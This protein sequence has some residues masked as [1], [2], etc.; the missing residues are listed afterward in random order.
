MAVA[1]QGKVFVRSGGGIVKDSIPE[2]NTK[3]R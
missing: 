2:M 3:K 1:K